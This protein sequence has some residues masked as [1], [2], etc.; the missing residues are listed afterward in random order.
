[1]GFIPILLVDGC[2]KKTVVDSEKAHLRASLNLGAGAVEV[3][4]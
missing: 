2:W 4:K 1:M 3:A